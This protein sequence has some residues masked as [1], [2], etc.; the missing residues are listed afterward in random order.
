MT[1][2]ILHGEDLIDRHEL[3]FFLKGNTSLD[4]VEEKSPADWISIGG[5]KDMQMLE[6]ASEV[7]KTFI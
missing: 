1:I 4:D 6:K 5:W 3:D 7:F 2:D